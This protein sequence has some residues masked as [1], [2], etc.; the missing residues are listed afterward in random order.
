[1]K[2]WLFFLPFPLV[3]LFSCGEPAQRFIEPQPAGQK[4]IGRFPKRFQ[5][6]YLSLSDSSMLTVTDNALIRSYDVWMEQELSSLDSSYTLI[7]DSLLAK[8]GEKDTL[9]VKRTGTL[10]SCHIFVADTFFTIDAPWTALRKMKGYL[11]LNSFCGD[12]CWTAEKMALKNGKLTIGEL[13]VPEDIEKLDAITETQEDTATVIR[14]YQPKRKEF[15]KFVKQ[16]GF[17]NEE[18][19]VKIKR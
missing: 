15:R 5:G 18:E 8:K 7:G 4:D 11:F 14:D 1:M 16:S 10:I 3:S 13:A 19:F 17:S 12:S 9:N 2:K 6:T